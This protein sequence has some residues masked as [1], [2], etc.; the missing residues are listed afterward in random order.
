MAAIY[1][2]AHGAWVAAMGHCPTFSDRFRLHAAG[3]AP[4]A[5]IVRATSLSLIPRAGVDVGVC[6]SPKQ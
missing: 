5:M 4:S 1:W 2:S 6:V 3:M